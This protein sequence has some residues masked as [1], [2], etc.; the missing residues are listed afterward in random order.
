MTIN[1]RQDELISDFALFDDWADKYAYIIELGKKLEG[2]EE[3][4]KLPENI[5]KGCQSNVWLIANKEGNGNIIFRAD[6]DA[7]IVKGLV[8]ML[9]TV[10]SNHTPEEIMRADLYFMEKIGMSQHLSPTRS[11][12]LAAMMKQMKF[13]AIAMS[14]VK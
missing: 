11:N 13:Y 2:I 5:I 7:I 10:L 4:Y 8:Y 1:E 3:E 9:L 14:T 6:S 12:G